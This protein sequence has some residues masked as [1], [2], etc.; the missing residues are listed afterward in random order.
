[1]SMIPT[2]LVA[3]EFPFVPLKKAVQLLGLTEATV[4]K[5]GDSGEIKSRRDEN[6]ERLF[7]RASIARYLRNKEAE[8]NEA[9]YEESRRQMAQQ[10]AEGRARRVK[11]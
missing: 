7:S 8:R 10:I 6:N 11:P 4:R 5:L 9:I 2:P 1:M 3:R